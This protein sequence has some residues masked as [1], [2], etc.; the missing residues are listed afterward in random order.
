MGW[1]SRG[2]LA[3]VTSLLV[4]ILLLT[5]WNLDPVSWMRV[6]ANKTLLG[7]LQS[8]VT[9]LVVLFG[10]SL[11][12]FRFFAY[13]FVLYLADI[14]ASVDVLPHSKQQ[15]L[16][17]LKLKVANRG[18]FR[19]RIENLRWDVIDYPTHAGANHENG[20][21]IAGISAD[22]LR[23]QIIDRG[24]T[25]DLMFI[26]RIVDKDSIASSSY[27]VTMRASGRIWYAFCAVSNLLQK[28]K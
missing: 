16:H 11:A 26:G 10:A 12:Y 17:F 27:H 18:T 28:G 21:E 3:A 9:V 19:L 4:L 23:L 1:L 8:A 5:V 13:G 22:Q 15:N 20:A 7:S 14:E 25:I 24:E 6:E 2:F